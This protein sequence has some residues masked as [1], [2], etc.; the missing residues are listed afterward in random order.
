MKRLFVTLC[1]ALLGMG[2]QAQQKGDFALGVHAGMTFTEVEFINVKES[3][4]QLGIGVF[5]Q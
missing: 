4:R 3:T 2:A 1:A 5:G